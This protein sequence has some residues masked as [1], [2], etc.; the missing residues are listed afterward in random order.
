MYPRFIQKVKSEFFEALDH[1]IIALKYESFVLR[2]EVLDLDL[3][4]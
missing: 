2:L 4:N 1:C 3:Q